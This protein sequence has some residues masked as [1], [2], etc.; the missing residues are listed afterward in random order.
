MC[1]A[2]V[3]LA[4]GGG[5]GGRATTPLA[6]H[7][8]PSWTPRAGLATLKWNSTTQ[9]TLFLQIASHLDAADL[10]GISQ[11]RELFVAQWKPAP[12]QRPQLDIGP[13]FNANSCV[14]CH[15]PD[16]RV[17][18]F[19]Q[20]QQITPAILFR[21]GNVVGESHP[22]WVSNCRQMPLWAYQKVTPP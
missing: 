18:P 22:L 14:A 16:G 20:N 11:G 13:L 19:A 6:A 17:P 4:C 2:V 1:S 12:G 5:D 7:E 21:L 10:A 9:R 3:L 15:A 8:E